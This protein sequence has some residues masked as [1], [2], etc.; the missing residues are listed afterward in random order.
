MEY[1]KL[2]SRKILTFVLILAFLVPVVMVSN[3]TLANAF[4]Q[5][6]DNN[7]L[8]DKSTNPIN[9]ELLANA[10][11]NNIT[12]LALWDDNID[13]IVNLY[14]EGNYMY[15]AFGDSGLG[16]ID[17][18][19]L[20]P[21][22]VSI[23]DDY[24]VNNVFVLGSYAYTVNTTGVNIVDISNKANPILA[25]NFTGPSTIED[26]A[27][28]GTFVYTVDQ[29]RLRVYNIT[30]FKAPYQTDSYN[31]GT[32]FHELYVKDGI[33]YAALNDH[34]ATYN[35]TDPNNILAYDFITFNNIRDLTL[36]TNFVYACSQ[37][38][39]RVYNATTIN[40]IPAAI[41]SYAFN[42]T[43]PNNIFASGN[44][45]YIEEGDD[46]IA[47][48]NMANKSQ[49]LYYSEYRDT[50]NGI[51]IYNYGYY[52]FLYNTYT[53]EIMDIT[54]PLAINT[55]TIET[56]YGDST[57]IFIEE[58][59]AF[60]ADT[61]SLEIFD[62]SDPAN[63]DK[64]GVYFEDFQDINFVEV[65]N[66]Y[67][68]ILE[69]SY[70]EILDVTDLTNPV[71]VSNLSLPGYS[72]ED[73][74]V[75]DE[76]AYIAVGADGVLVVDIY[77][78]DAP[79]LSMVYDEH[80]DINGLDK[81]EDYLYLAATDYIHIIDMTNPYDPQE[82]GNFT[83]LG[84]IY[85]E[86]F[87][88]DDYLY[89]CNFDGIDILDITDI[90]EDKELETITIDI[91]KVGQYNTL[92]ITYDVFVDGQYIYMLDAIEGLV[93]LDATNIVHPKKIGQYD[94]DGTYN[95]V[96]ARNGYIYLS[97]GINGTRILI[98]EPQLTVKSPLNPYSLIA[99]LTFIAVFGLLYRKKRRK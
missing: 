77:Y 97:E 11:M 80:N 59:T 58:D 34:F 84:A 47:I 79:Q 32:V 31:E 15:I 41:S 88:L 91:A 3:I 29:S 76:F 56:Y 87:I 61:S 86:V 95:D 53:V 52:S 65:K 94:Y 42:N 64:I 17:L 69:Q 50:I 8:S 44:Y 93:I 13:E 16:I 96:W 43:G 82:L 78:P 4:D 26:I 54:N 14:V 55:T 68:Y 36:T 70:L 6:N 90:T 1:S 30:D 75:D 23:W 63:P 71:Y 24:T 83:R 99:G 9:N 28:N 73:F 38:E 51:D 37:A 89:A 92:T 22:I 40:S 98:T 60:V 7:N 27:S 74:Y 48:V 21:E 62:I 39:V 81:F 67:A 72:F 33:A 66:D 45:L 12:T 85:I 35:V 10:D 19:D 18:T 20:T 57:D 46:G 25:C 5:T 2:R 49:P